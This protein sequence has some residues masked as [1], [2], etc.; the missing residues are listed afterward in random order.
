MAAFSAEAFDAAQPQAFY[1][2]ERR[3]EMEALADATLIVEGTRLQGRYVQA[4]SA[5]CCGVLAACSCTLLPAASL[6]VQFLAQQSGVLGGMFADLAGA[7]SLQALRPAS[8][9]AASAAADELTSGRKRKEPEPEQGSGRPQLVTVRWRT[10]Q[11]V[12][13]CN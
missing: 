7:A 3:A 8:A 5:W 10:L 12:A 2:L 13:F 9:A 1:L 6:A 11:L 4:C